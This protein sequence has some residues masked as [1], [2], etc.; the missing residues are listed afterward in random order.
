MKSVRYIAVSVLC[1]IITCCALAET[2]VLRNGETAEG[3]VVKT[4]H[5]RVTIRIN[6]GVLEYDLEDFDNTTREKHF[7]HVG[8][9]EPLG[10]YIRD[11]PSGYQTNL[12]NVTSFDVN[13]AGIK[14]VRVREILG[15]GDYFVEFTPL[16]VAED[17]I[18]SASAVIIDPNTSEKQAARVSG[19]NRKEITSHKMHGST[20]VR[21]Q[22]HLSEI[23]DVEADRMIRQDWMSLLKYAANSKHTEL[24]CKV[25][26][27][28]LDS[29]AFATNVLDAVYLSKLGSVDYYDLFM[30]NITHGFPKKGLR[31]GVT[32]RMQSGGRVSFT[33]QLPQIRKPPLLPSSKL[34]FKF[35]PMGDELVA[36]AYNQ[37]LLPGAFRFRCG[38]LGLRLV[39]TC[40]AGSDYDRI[41]RRIPSLGQ[42][43]IDYREIC[44]V[45][46]T[47]DSNQ[48]ISGTG[49]I[50]PKGL[51]F[52]YG[53]LGFDQ[54]NQSQRYYVIGVPRGVERIDGPNT[55]HNSKTDT[56]KDA[57]IQIPPMA[58]RAFKLRIHEATAKL[59][60]G[61]H[62]LEFA[63]FIEEEE[64]AGKRWRCHHGAF[65]LTKTETDAVIHG[66]SNNIRCS[67]LGLILTL[68]P[69]RGCPRS[70]RNIISELIS[71]E[72]VP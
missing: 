39:P 53:L 5:P 42:A 57:Y 26:L 25:F 16:D 48:D 37:G 69:P 33:L 65:E 40:I 67:H 41:K 70:P 50:L 20:S 17:R 8:P 46:I 6:A 11:L 18:L 49:T 47:R 31:L 60:P 1:C 54:P 24:D 2:F 14:E 12:L 63:L 28:T 45:E 72:K 66:V 71:G 30:E 13:T 36:V 34:T 23:T 38:T 68:E 29:Y 43:I 27:K 56:K 44:P 21:C 32:L 7:Q 22:V 4:K 35:K 19:N 64:D 52:K 62:S 51:R 55:D 58:T 59:A 15:Y 10:N 9:G 61:N 3:L